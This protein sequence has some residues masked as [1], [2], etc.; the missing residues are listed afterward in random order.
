MGTLRNKLI[1]LAHQRP[2]LRSNLLPL[3]RQGGCEKLPEGGMRDNCE[4]KKKE[5]ESKKASRLSLDQI[6]DYLI[7]GM[8]HE[9]SPEDAVQT[10]VSWGYKD[11]FVK[12]L[13]QAWEK[14]RPDLN[15]AHQQDLAEDL[16]ERVM[17]KTGVRYT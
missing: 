11:R 12:A 13:I 17:Q 2:E 9:E 10:L 14:E 6:L 8:E 15:P 16:V 5:G 3:L 7:N 4:A 1:R